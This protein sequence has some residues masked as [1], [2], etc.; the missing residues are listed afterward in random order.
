M[1]FTTTVASIFNVIAQATNDGGVL[2]Y[3]T[4]K[5]TAGGIFMHP[6][7]ASLII[8]LAFS[9]E[10][11]WTLTK[12]RTNTKKFIVDVKKRI[13]S[14]ILSLINYHT[15]SNDNQL[16]IS[17]YL[18]FGRRLLPPIIPDCPAFIPILCANLA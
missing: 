3:L 2:N 15:L 12:A 14:E 7:L 11:L 8:G 10:R 13:P 18:I 9:F 17:D 16:L 1:D 4:E 6:I 5:Y